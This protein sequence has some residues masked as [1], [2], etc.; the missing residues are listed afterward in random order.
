[1]ESFEQDRVTIE[2][3]KDGYIADATFC[4][5]AL[6]RWPVA[7][8]EIDRLKSMLAAIAAS[9]TEKDAML[10][11][12]AEEAAKGSCPCDYNGKFA[13]QDESCETDYA[14]KPKRC[15]LEYWE[16][17]VNSKASGSAN[18]PDL[19]KEGEK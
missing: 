13:Q 2:D 18:I 10:A 1:M 9:V 15:W 17:K 16:R 6:Q 12:A 5:H 4:K 14:E 7:L 8:Q 3:L 11:L 19:T